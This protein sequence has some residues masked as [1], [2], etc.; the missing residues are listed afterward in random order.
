MN[1][2]S[3]ECQELFLDTKKSGLTEV[4]LLS[5]WI[6]ECGYP[7][8]LNFLRKCFLGPIKVTIFLKILLKGQLNWIF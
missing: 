8:K 6:I 3:R 7:K 5:K 2:F 1:N 4:D